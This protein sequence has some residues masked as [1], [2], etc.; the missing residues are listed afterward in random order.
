YSNCPTADRF[1]YPQ[2]FDN[3]T[4][5]LRGVVATKQ[6]ILSFAARWI[7]S[8]SISSGAHSRDAL[9][10][11]DG[12]DGFASPGRRSTEL[13]LSLFFQDASRH[14]EERSDEA[15]QTAS[16]VRFLIASLRSQ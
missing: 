3:R 2:L 15:I 10:R 11:N 16:A 8:R 12:A 5:S 14:C 13:R 1:Y 7:A 6:S 4:T 9:A